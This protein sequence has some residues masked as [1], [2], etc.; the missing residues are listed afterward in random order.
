MNEKPGVWDR[1]RAWLRRARRPVGI[2]LFGY[3]CALG[4]VNLVGSPAVGNNVFHSIA[5]NIFP[6]FGSGGNLD[7]QSIQ[8]EWGYIQSQYVIRGVSTSGVNLGAEEGIIVYLH[9]TFGDRFSAVLP[10]QDNSNLQDELSGKLN[11]GIGI[12]LEERCG[13]TTLCTGNA[14]PTVFVIENV[15]IGMPA[16]HAGI[17]NNDILEAVNGKSA[18]T[19]GASLDSLIQPIINN[20]KGKAGTSVAL[21]VKRGFSTLSFT[22]TRQDLQIPSV[23]SKLFGSV[24]YVEITGFDSNTASAIKQQ[25]QQGLNQGAKGVVLDLRENGGG[26]VDAAQTVASQFLTPGSKEQDVVVRRGRLD[27][28]GNPSSAQNVVHDQI[29]QGGLVP[30]LPMA[31]LVNGDSA[32]ASEI[33]TMALRDYKR[34]TI[35]GTQTFGKGSVQ[36][37]FALPDGN[38]LHLTIEKWFGPNGESIDGNGITPAIVVKLPSLLD[39]FRLETKS[40]DPSTDTQL[41]QALSVVNKLIGNG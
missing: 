29:Q 40:V 31:V 39:L 18:Y 20:V 24:L 4:A 6:R 2:V 32:S 5:L 15:L 30:K 16:D 34:A 21:T 10:P 28:S 19:S 37:D 35:V 38:D 1:F 8:Q 22:V 17:Q 27:L 36:T 13:A 33:V 25:L 14:N 12:A 3:I 41:H 9:D 26:L 11:G 7:T 23:Y